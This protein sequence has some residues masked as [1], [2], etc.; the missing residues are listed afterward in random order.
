MKYWS[1]AEPMDLDFQFIFETQVDSYFDVFKPVSDL[2]NIAAPGENEYGF[3]KPPSPTMKMILGQGVKLFKNL[4]TFGG[5]GGSVIQEGIDFAAGEITK[6]QTDAKPTGYVVELRIGNNF[7]FVPVL[8]KSVTPTFSSEL[9]YAPWR[10]INDV[11]N[12]VGDTDPLSPY[13]LPDAAVKAI[14]QTICS[15]MALG[16][17][18]LSSTAALASSFIKP[19]LLEKLV[20]RLT[21]PSYPIRAEVNMSVEL[22]FPLTKSQILPALKADHNIDHVFR[23][24][25]YD[26]VGY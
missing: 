10:A 5:E 23:K 8:I 12:P 21:M 15:A 22:Q 19:D 6:L 18:F 26:N 14:S 16:Q 13:L 2:L 3:M 1:G 11:L 25:G 17:G 24:L 9:A 20:E 4:G 7:R